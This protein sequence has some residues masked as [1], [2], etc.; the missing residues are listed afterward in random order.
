MSKEMTDRL[1]ALI[2]VLDKPI[3]TDDAEGIIGAIS[4]IKGVASVD[5]HVADLDSYIAE[6]NAYLDLRKKIGEIL[7]PALRKS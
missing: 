4:H 1:N 6:T 7:W 3:R 5:T 2:V